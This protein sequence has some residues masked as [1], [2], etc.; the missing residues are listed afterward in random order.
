MRVQSIAVP[1][2]TDKLIDTFIS[3]QPP[4][5]TKTAAKRLAVSQ[6]GNFAVFATLMTKY[7]TTKSGAIV[8]PPVSA[9]F[10]SAP[11]VDGTVHVRLTYPDGS[12]R[13]LTFAPPDL[14]PRQ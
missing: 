12:T 10:E 5:N 6:T 3:S 4:P 9:A 13:S 8:A 2:Q 7:T 1:G 14:S 11:A